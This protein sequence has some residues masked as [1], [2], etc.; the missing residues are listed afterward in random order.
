MLINHYIFK[1]IKEICQTYKK[2]VFSL[3][4]ITKNKDPIEAELLFSSQLL[5]LTEKQK[6]KQKS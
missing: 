1:D 5:R 6:Q 2:I 3:V 4:P